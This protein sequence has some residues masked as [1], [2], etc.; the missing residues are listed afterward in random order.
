MVSANPGEATIF[1][2]LTQVP[3]DV[4]LRLLKA[5]DRSVLLIHTEHLPGVNSSFF[6][7]SPVTTGLLVVC[8]CTFTKSGF[9]STTQ[10]SNTVVVT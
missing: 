8:E 10:D 7:F 1:W 2:Q 6:A 4:V 5:S 9:A 3:D